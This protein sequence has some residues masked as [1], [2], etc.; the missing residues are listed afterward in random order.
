MADYIDPDVK[1]ELQA[2]GGAQKVPLFGSSRAQSKCLSIL[3]V[4][5]IWSVNFILK[6]KLGSPL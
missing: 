6:K 2:M 3:V 1:D 5:L 4:Y